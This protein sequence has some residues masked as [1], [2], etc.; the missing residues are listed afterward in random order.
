MIREKIT[1]D[2]SWQVQLMELGTLLEWDQNIPDAALRRALADERYAQYLF[3]VRGKS[4]LLQQLLNHPENAKYQDAPPKVKAQG[5]FE[6]V[7]KATKALMK[8]GRSGFKFAD[9]EV[10]E[11]RENACLNCEHLMSPQTMLQRLVT[12]GK[13]KDELGKRAGDSVCGLCGC[14]IA[15]KIKLPTE[16]CPAAHAEKSGYS[17]WDELLKKK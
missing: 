16:S 14:G 10:L 4:D 11:Q 17:R 9:S 15:N 8:W 3:S 5:N 1:S 7:G 6:L 12:S 2:Q 13:T